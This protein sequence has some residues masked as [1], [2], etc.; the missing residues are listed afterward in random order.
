MRRVTKENENLFQRHLRSGW[1]FI[2]S[3]FGYAGDD[4][5]QGKAAFAAK[6]CYAYIIVGS[7]FLLQMMAM[8]DFN[9]N[10]VALSSLSPNNRHLFPVST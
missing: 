5:A 8:F 9:G 3:R 2:Y 6:R 1:W 7:N 10:A 4:A